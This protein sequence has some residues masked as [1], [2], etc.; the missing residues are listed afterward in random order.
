M[1]QQPHTRVIRQEAG[2]RLKGE[3]ETQEAS[4]LAGVLR[5]IL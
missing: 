4:G 3:E 5:I 1:V 2:T